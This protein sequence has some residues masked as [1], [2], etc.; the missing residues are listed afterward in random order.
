MESTTSV[1]TYVCL[2]TGYSIHFLMCG[3]SW[4]CAPS[5]AGLKFM[6]FI[7]FTFVICVEEKW[8]NLC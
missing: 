7:S 8:L 1:L 4:P 3:V 2:S 6:S 5:S